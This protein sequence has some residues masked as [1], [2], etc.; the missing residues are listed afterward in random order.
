MKER[1]YDYE[2]QATEG[3][4]LNEY[5]K[6]HNIIKRIQQTIFSANLELNRAR[7]ASKQTS[8][9]QKKTQTYTQWCFGNVPANIQHHN[10]LKKTYKKS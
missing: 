8:V 1:Q 7:N 3:L 10:T 9:F 2:C 4:S 5:K 6:I